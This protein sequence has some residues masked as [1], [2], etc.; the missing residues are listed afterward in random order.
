MGF[1]HDEKQRGTPVFRKQ[2]NTNL[3]SK[4]L[5]VYNKNQIT[6]GITIHQIIFHIHVK[7]RNDRI[8]GE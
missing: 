8:Y 7:N 2:S 6:D 5:I 1:T 4:W 3:Q